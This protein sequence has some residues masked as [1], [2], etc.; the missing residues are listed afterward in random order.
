MCLF[1]M[2]QKY[3]TFILIYLLKHVGFVSGH[4]KGQ[5]YPSINVGGNGDCYI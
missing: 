2:L 5:T 1:R 3:S 4:T